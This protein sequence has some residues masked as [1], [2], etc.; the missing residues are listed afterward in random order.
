MMAAVR[1]PDATT[2]EALRTGRGGRLSMRVNEASD[3]GALPRAVP[4]GFLVPGLDLG[5][6]ASEAYY[7]GCEVAAVT[8]GDDEA[9]SASGALAAIIAGLMVGHSLAEAADVARGFALPTV[10]GALGRA[11]TKRELGSAGA[12]QTGG[13]RGGPG[14]ALEALE[15]ALGCARL[16]TFD[17]AMDRVVSLPGDARAIGSICG[18]LIGAR[19]GVEAIPETRLAWLDGRSVVEEVAD[20]CVEWLGWLERAHEG[21][22]LGAAWLARYG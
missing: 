14:S 18:S 22:E 12:V 4:A 15:L 6:S 13:L 7:V 10:A 17:E 9:I 19:D 21:A 16:D 1:H 20:D 11:Q 5:A 2:L 3:A 8:H